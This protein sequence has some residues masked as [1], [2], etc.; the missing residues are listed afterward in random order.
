MALW[1]N[2]N[3]FALVH[4]VY[5]IL[6]PRSWISNTS[7]WS[8]TG[9]IHTDVISSCVYPKDPP[10]ATLLIKTNLQCLVL[11]YHFISLSLSLFLLSQYTFRRHRG[12][13][14]TLVPVHGAGAGENIERTFRKIRQTCTGKADF[15]YPN[16]PRCCI[17]P[18]LSISLC[19]Q[20]T[21][22]WFDCWISS[23]TLLIH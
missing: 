22:C 14:E 21:P 12:I 15:F 11:T 6:F 16:S 9:V 18:S 20:S 7:Q 3:T 19:F 13:H 2:Y 5:N 23:L 10:P 17:K 8:M 1:R 4:F